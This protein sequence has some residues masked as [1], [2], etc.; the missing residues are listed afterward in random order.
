MKK[1]IV[2][3]ATLAMLV[4]LTACSGMVTPSPTV[5]VTET[6]TATATPTPTPT[7][8]A[9]TPAE[10]RSG[11]LTDS[12]FVSFARDARPYLNKIPQKTMLDFVNAACNAFDRGA[13][14]TEVGKVVTDHAKSVE[15]S[16]A[17]GFLIGA[18]TRIYC[19]EHA[20]KIDTP[21]S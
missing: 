10:S 12:E 15:E 18:G 1:L 19:P 17:L 7:P 13:T 9:T 8:K 6:Q 14:A 21:K 4:G 5:T 3:L 16:G 20:S 2:L 11:S